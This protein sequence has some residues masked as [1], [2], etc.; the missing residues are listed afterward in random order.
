VFSSFA[1]LDV[2]TISSS[3]GTSGNIIWGT[4]LSNLES[5]IEG[6]LSGL[7]YGPVT[8]GGGGTVTLSFSTPAPQYFI[9]GQAVLFGGVEYIVATASST[10][11]TATQQLNPLA[12]PANPPLTG[13]G[14]SSGP[15]EGYDENV[16]FYTQAMEYSGLWLYINPFNPGSQVLAFAE[17]YPSGGPESSV[18]G[19]DRWSDGVFVSL[20]EGLEFQEQGFLNTNNLWPPPTITPT[21]M[22]GIIKF[23][24]TVNNP[25]A[26]PIVFTFYATLSNTSGTFNQ[27]EEMSI[28]SGAFGTWATGTAPAGNFLGGDGNYANAAVAVVPS[29]PNVVFVGGEGTG[30]DGT[31]IV[32][33]SLNG[34]ASWTDISAAPYTNV[35]SSAIYSMSAF[36]SGGVDYLLVGTDGGIW[37]F[38]VTLGTWTDINGN[39]DVTQFNSIATD[40]TSLGAILGAI[41]GNGAV[42]TT[43]NT[44]WNYVDAQTGN[45][46]QVQYDPTLQDP[47]LVFLLA[48]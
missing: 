42:L 14:S 20:N 19:L 25:Q 15:V 17:S 22:S 36:T 38:N 11:I 18:G 30:I 23:A 35:P 37:R 32:Y 41:V 26:S 7:G 47:N 34:G 13:L 1:T 9:V 44:Q 33:E 27:I 2:F 10:G 43:G 5:N 8:V 12:P 4:N 24:A 45:A 29:Q 21:P 3:A 31:S 16:F 28:T 40:P 6:A 39:L 48:I 46:V